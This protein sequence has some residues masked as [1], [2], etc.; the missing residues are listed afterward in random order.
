MNTLKKLGKNFIVLLFWL[1]V[2]ELLALL[3]GKPL[4]LPDPPTVLARLGTLVTTAAF[5]AITAVSLLRILCGALIAL[6]LGTALAV[7][8]CRFK[9][10]DALF[11]PL[12][13]VI[14]STPVAS[15]II[16]VLIWVGRDYVPSLIVVLMV[17]PVVWGNVTA[18]VRNTDPLLLRTARVFRFSRARTLRRVYIP[19]VMPYFLSACRTSLGLAWKAGIAAE[20]LTVP[21]RSIGKMLYES[22]LYLET[23]DLFAWTLVVIVCSLVIEKVLMAAVGRLGKS[24]AAGGE[25]A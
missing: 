20:V 3:V 13:T 18:G 4:L 25:D 19:S 10:M 16:L 14:K 12:L 21:A 22:K 15:F 6:A 23:V 8:T 11:S 17:L 1:A 2:W 7:L 9:A 24:Y 5:W